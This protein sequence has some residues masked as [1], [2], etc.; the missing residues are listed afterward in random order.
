MADSRKF[1]KHSEYRFNEAE[2]RRMLDMLTGDHQ[3][4]T[5]P[6]YLWLHPME[7]PKRSCD[8]ADKELANRD[9]ASRAERTQ[10]INYLSM[11][12]D[13]FKALVL[14]G[15]FNLSDEVINLL[16]DSEKNV[17]GNDNSLYQFSEDV[18]EDILSYGTA[19]VYTDTRTIYSQDEKKSL[20]RP[21]WTRIHPLDL[22]DWQVGDD[23]K[24]E[25]FRFEYRLLK[26]R[27][28]LEEEPVLAHQ[29]TVGSIIDGK[30]V[31]HT[32]GSVDK[33]ANLINYSP[34]CKSDKTHVDWKLVNTPDLSDNITMLP[35]AVSRISEPALKQVVPIALKIYNKQSELD[36]ILHDQCYDKL[37]VFAELPSDTSGEGEPLSEDAKTVKISTN[38]LIVIP[39][40]E[41]AH[42]EKLTPTHPLALMESLNNNLQDLFLIAFKMAK[43]TR[44]DSD[45][46]EAADTKREAKEDLF[47][48]VESW[49]KKLL[50]VLNAAVKHY[51]MFKGEKDFEGEISYN[52]ELTEEDFADLSKNLIMHKDRFSQF[53]EWEKSLNKKLAKSHRLP[54]QKDILAEIES[55][56]LPTLEEQQEAAAEQSRGKIEGLV[57]KDGAKS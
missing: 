24:Y 35:L 17:D 25:A 11:V 13:R 34:E 57:K 48:E 6:K 26:P 12:R 18:V 39:P 23:G 56:T 14:K 41:G 29:T 7:D 10:Y 28:S 5:D 43:V 42:T 1:H 22:M 38:S 37:F 32:Y 53:P 46:A 4:M 33:N 52:E 3:C 49:R 20:D 8:A 40:G 15:G 45:I 21:Y 55:T 51:A 54:N 19:Y 2:W 50:D 27:A 36:N 47:T 30:Y 44:A 16:G 31:V 9:R